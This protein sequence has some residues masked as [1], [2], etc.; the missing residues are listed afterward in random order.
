MNSETKNII[1]QVKKILLIYLNVVLNKT[2]KYKL[3]HDYGKVF[4]SWHLLPS[5]RQKSGRAKLKAKNKCA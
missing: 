4:V 3:A 2:W 1:F 5:E